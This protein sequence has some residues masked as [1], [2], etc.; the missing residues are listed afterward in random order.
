VL[1]RKITQ[2]K[3]TV[4]WE[5]I[6]LICVAVMGDLHRKVV[7]EEIWKGNEKEAIVTSMKSNLGR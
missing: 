3:G 1:W 6:S 4:S 5:G 7:C 2:R